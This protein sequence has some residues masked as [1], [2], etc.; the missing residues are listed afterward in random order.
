[1]TESQ[2]GNWMPIAV[3]GLHVTGS[4]SDMVP[5]QCDESLKVALTRT[6]PFS[7]HESNCRLDVAAVITL[8]TRAIVCS[9]ERHIVMTSQKMTKNVCIC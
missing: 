9:F 5:S 6:R 2:S 1:M 7:P 3:F 8:K 4:T